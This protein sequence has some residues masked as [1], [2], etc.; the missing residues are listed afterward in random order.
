MRKSHLIVTLVTLLSSSVLFANH[1]DMS[2]DSACGVIAKA[3]V[4]AGYSRDDHDKKFWMDCM[5]PVVLGKSV[6]NVDVDAATVKSCRTDKI[7][8]MKNELNEMEKVSD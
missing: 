5:K 4:K 6:K 3:C 8:K 1:S 7:A 2:D